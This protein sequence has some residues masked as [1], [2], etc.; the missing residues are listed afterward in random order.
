MEVLKNLRKK[1]ALAVRSIQWSY[2]IFWSVSPRQPGVLEWGD[3]Y[4]NG[5]IKTRKT[6]QAAELN[7]DQLGLQRSDQLRELYES[8]S[9]GETNPQ[10]KR[11]TAA[12]SPEDLT[13]A[14]CP[15]YVY[16]LFEGLIEV[17]DISLL[18]NFCI[19]PSYGWL[20]SLRFSECIDPGGVVELGATELVSEDP[21]LIQHIKTSFLENPSDTVSQ[22]PNYVSNIINDHTNM[23]EDGLD[24]LLD[25]PD[26]DITSPNDCSNEF[27][28]NLLREE[29][30]LVEG[31]DG[32]ASQIQ[33]WPFMDDAISNCLNN[34]ANS[35]DCISQTYGEPETIV[36]LSD[37]KKETNSCMQ[38]TQECNNSGLQG[39]DI[40]YKSVLSNLLKSSHQLILGPYFRN[41]SRRSSFVSW[42]KDG[43]AGGAQLGQSGNRQKMLKKVLFEVARMHENCRLESVKQN[44]DPKPEVDEIDRN[45]VLSER[46]RR[47]KINERFTILGSL[48]PSGGK[49]DKVSILDH[50]IEYLRDLERKVE[51]LESYKEAME[52]EST[53]RNKPQ[54]AIE[55]T[56]DN[57]GPN[58][59][60]NTKK[61][62]T[63]KRKACEMEKTGAENNR[64]RLRDTSADNIAVSVSDKG[65]SIEMKCS[66]KEGIMLEVMGAISKLRMDTENVQSSNTDGILSITI[67]AKCKGLKAASASVI[68]QALQ[69]VI[70]KC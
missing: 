21:N 61:P 43:I 35:S 23:S 13:D 39:N 63:N 67:K 53:T 44:A 38:E 25:C 10:A 36:P 5:D 50:T 59:I 69:K 20:D 60:G 45:H 65:V 51:E 12:L 29:S 14:E 56:S 57:Y 40:H 66:W 4:Y 11:P 62:S 16:V 8:L 34:S 47:E 68:R 64:V 48:V 31:I 42:R 17:S 33:S 37:N 2:A 52:L 27:A 55:R 6:V 70:R 3:G 41:G 32:E 49:V 46:K 19:L 7:P 26:M 54:D 30:N 58:K 18:L 1:L 28:D 15:K 9:L 24:Q 22:I